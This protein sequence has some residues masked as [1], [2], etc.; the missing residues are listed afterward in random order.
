MYYLCYLHGPPKYPGPR[1]LVLTD[2]S[3][4]GRVNG[5]QPS[6]LCSPYTF[7]YMGSATL[8]LYFY[9]AP[10]QL[11]SYQSLIRLSIFLQSISYS[12]FFY[13]LVFT[14]TL[15]TSASHLFYYHNRTISFYLIVIQY[16]IIIAINTYGMDKLLCYSLFKLLKLCLFI[17]LY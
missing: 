9:R 17:L 1:T 11:S 15:T 16:N 3:L 13:L 14:T 8:V 10:S 5:S 12:L 6:S 2:F 7:N 4:K